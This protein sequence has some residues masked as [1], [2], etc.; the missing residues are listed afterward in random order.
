MTVL[1]IAEIVPKLKDYVLSWHWICLCY[2]PRCFPFHFRATLVPWAASWNWCSPRMLKSSQLVS[3]PTV[4]ATWTAHRLYHTD[5]VDA[6]GSV[7]AFHYG[8]IAVTGGIG[9]F[10]SQCPLATCILSWV[11]M[12]WCHLIPMVLPPVHSTESANCDVCNK[13]LSIKLSGTVETASCPKFSS[14]LEPLYG[15]MPQGHLWIAHYC[16]KICKECTVRLV[17]L[18]WRLWSGLC[19]RSNMQR[20]PLGLATMCTH[21]LEVHYFFSF[22]FFSCLSTYHVISEYWSDFCRMFLI[23]IPVL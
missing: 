11:P 9:S 17:N 5:P 16:A 12:Q 13:P 10:N 8:D 15:W 23:D 1:F 2:V 18:S 19:L 4:T 21:P 7:P 3:C 20:K 6:L 14:R 22:F